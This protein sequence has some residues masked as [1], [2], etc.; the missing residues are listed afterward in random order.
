[1]VKWVDCKNSRITPFNVTI[2]IIGSII[3]IFF[4]SVMNWTKWIMDQNSVWEVIIIIITLKGVI[5]DFSQS[6]HCAANCLQHVHSSD[7]GAIVCKSHA[8]DRALI[9]CNM[10]CC[11]P[12]GMKGKISYSSLTELR[13]HLFELYFIGW[14][15]KSMKEGK[16]PEYPEKTPGDELQ[17][18]PHTTVQRFKP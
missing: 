16:K 12:R 2:S 15:I 3:I 17:K 6:P 9:T 13:S 4:L 11:V 18:M 14:T 7:P 1:M 8:T 10:S 5:R